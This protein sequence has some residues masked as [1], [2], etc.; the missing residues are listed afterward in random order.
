MKKLSPEITSSIKRMLTVIREEIQE[1]LLK[2]SV[3]VPVE[4]FYSDE[5][6]LKIIPFTAH[7]FLFLTR[8]L[9]VDKATIIEWFN[10]GLFIEILPNVIEYTLRRMTIRKAN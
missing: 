4:E 5:E 2:W 1:D 6:I 9:R 7:E 3:F 10:W 8:G